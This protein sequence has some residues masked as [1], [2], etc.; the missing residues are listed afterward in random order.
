MRITEHAP[1]LSRRLFLLGGAALLASLSLPGSGRALSVSQAQSLV[2]Q[3]SNELDSLVNSG[4]G[5][6]Q[7]YAGFERILSRYGDM[8]AV[9]A[10]SLGPAWRSASNAQR[11]AYISAFQGYLARKYG[12]QF[13]DYRNA[14]IEVTGGRDAGRAGVLVNTTV[15]RPGRENIAVD[16][17]VSDR[18]GS[19]KA[20]NLIIEGVS[21]LANERAEIGAML[22]AQGGDINGLIAQLNRR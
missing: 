10:S 1:A 17:Q 8:R 12:R 18:S 19:A 3:I 5:S 9:G 21:L 22:D 15:I 16:W 4:R 14:R 20:V 13:E 2:V 6:S 7:I 11:S